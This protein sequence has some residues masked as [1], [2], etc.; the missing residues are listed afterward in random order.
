MMKD[1]KDQVTFL[2]KL[3]NNFSDI[4]ELIQKNNYIILEPKKR[5]ISDIMLT[6]YFYYNHI[7]YKSP[8]DESLYINLNGK[9]LKYEHPKFK[10]FLGWNKDMILTIKDSTKLFNDI[11]CFQLDNVC[12]DILYSETKSTS[13]K[14]Q[15]E[16]KKTREEYVKY[17]KELLKEN[18]SYN[19]SFDRF[20]KFIREMKINY[21]F[22]KGFEENYSKTF[23]NRKMKLTKRFTEILRNPKDEYNTCYNITSELVDSLVFDSL[24]KYLFE[25]CLVKFYSEEEGKIRKVF[26]DFPSKYDWDAMNINEVFYKCKFEPAIHYLNNITSK[27]TIFEKK[28]VLK[29]VNNLITEEAKNIYESQQKKNFN[30]DG[31]DL[32]NFWI[33]VI[34]HCN[35]PN[36]L[37]EAKFMSLFGSFGYSSDDY[38]AINFASAANG[39]QDEILKNDK[40][41]SQ[42]IEPKKIN[43]SI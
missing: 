23:N 7:F 16:K 13:N 10:T 32:L 4:L 8:Y 12:D 5:I 22:M 1:Q 27:K 39:I 21:V 38:I 29:E 15:L 17:N 43:I 18:E 34:A 41:T 19:K 36:I 28:E 2:S 25:E 9:V 30:L 6:K 31:N 26:K 3:K 37:A 42:H 35:T 11:Q 20:K 14:N 33:Y 24:Y 40:I